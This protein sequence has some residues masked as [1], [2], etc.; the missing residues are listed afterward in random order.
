MC[1][2]KTY[3]SRRFLCDFKYLN[4]LDIHPLQ[5]TVNIHKVNKQYKVND[6]A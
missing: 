2:W 4:G 3:I 5:I 1:C 6:T